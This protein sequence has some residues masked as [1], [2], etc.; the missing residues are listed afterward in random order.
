MHFQKVVSYKDFNVVVLFIQILK[1]IEMLPSR[2]LCLLNVFDIFGFNSGSSKVSSYFALT[3]FIQ[4]AHISLLLGL[5]WYPFV[6]LIQKYAEYGSMIIVLNGYLQYL[7]Q[8]LSCWLIALDSFF[9][10]RAHKRFWAIFQQ[11]NK[12]LNHTNNDVQ[13]DS[14]NH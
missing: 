10:R 3:C 5:T 1:Y 8:L 2:I 7:S 4:L 6:W 9:H 14:E 13:I 12:C 11:M